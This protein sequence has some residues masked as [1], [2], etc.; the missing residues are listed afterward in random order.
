[1]DAHQQTQ[2][3]VQQDLAHCW[4]PFTPQALWGKESEVLMLESGRGV[5]LTDSLGRRYIDGNS[6]IWVNIHGH[7]HPHIVQAMQRQ[8]AKLCHSSYLGFGHGLASAL[9]E[10]LVALFP[11]GTLTRVF[12]SDDGS[13]AV[14]TALKMA[15]QSCVQ[16]PGRE[17]R[18]HFVAFANC[19]HGDTMGA[20]SLGGVGTFFSRFRG[21]GMEVTHVR[22]LEELRAKPQEFLDTLAGVVIEPIIQGVNRMTPWPKGL[23]RE[24][25]EFCT[26]QGIYLICDEVMTGFGRTGRMFACMHEEVTPDFLC[27]AKGL[28]AG[29]TPMA[30]CL[31]TEAVYERFLGA[32]S[33]NKTFYYGHSFTAHPIGC[34]AAM[35]SLD[36][37]EQEHVLEK[38]PPKV[39]LMA[40]LAEQLRCTE[41]HVAAVR[42]CGMVMGIDITRADGSSYPQDARA[43]ERACMAMRAHGLLT[44][45]V[46]HDTLVLMPPLCIEE[47]EI[48]QMFA[49]LAAG[50]RDALQ[51][52]L[53]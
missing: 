10:R 28:T 7:C 39:A 15:F 48:R 45:P 12:Y 27:C 16:T 9:A 32:Y 23:L 25:R 30:A 36:V 43:G 11:A 34:A 18:R 37:F 24:L 41:P 29:Y 4:H 1:M 42:Q 6:S 22:S 40:E 5:W 46:T 19:Y 20:A 14:E 31:T 8:A 13:T 33:E 52:D 21:F 49:A 47:P 26:A 17:Q 35:A 2:Q 44:R 3:W 51:G 53:A 50:I 38:L